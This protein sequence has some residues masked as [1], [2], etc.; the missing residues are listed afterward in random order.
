MM[1]AVVALIAMASGPASASSSKPDSPG[2]P[3]SARPELLELAIAGAARRGDS[4]PHDVKAI[5]MSHRAAERILCGECESRVVPPSAPVYV[6]AMRGHFHCNI[7]SPPRGRVIGPAS[8][9]TLQF[10]V[11]NMQALESSYGGPYPNLRAAGTPVLLR[12]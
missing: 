10:L 2:I 4:H 1:L 12:R 8:V 7:C 5:R 6:I 11:S 3:S 9:I